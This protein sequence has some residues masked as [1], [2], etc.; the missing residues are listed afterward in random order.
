[1]KVTI[2]R[3]VGV[4]IVIAGLAG[5][6]ACNGSDSS[7]KKNDSLNAA[8]DSAKVAD[9]TTSAKAKKKKKGQTSVSGF[10]TDS[11]KMAKDIHGVYNRTDITPEFPGGQSALAA[12][13]NKN[14]VYPQSAVDNGTNGTVRVVFIV[15]EHGKVLHPQLT[16]SSQLGG[17]LA[18]ETLTAF[19]K[20]PLW[21]P[22]M[23][24]GKKVKTRLV[25][26]VSFELADADQ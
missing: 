5:S 13:I 4:F 7:D 26:P 16:D 22:G 24:N 23:V 18:Q 6:A 2:S 1:M 10:M 25:L 3:L 8:P 12:Y 15:D 21:T 20:M 11:A 9:S 14:I 19:N 17:E